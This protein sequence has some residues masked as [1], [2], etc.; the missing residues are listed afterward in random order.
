MEEGV[1]ISDD[2]DDSDQ[3]PEIYFFRVAAVW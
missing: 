3:F 2:E 1:F